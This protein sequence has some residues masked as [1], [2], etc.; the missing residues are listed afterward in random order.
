MDINK[1]I[2]ARIN[3]LLVKKNKKQKELSAFLGI[4]DNVVS[5][6]VHG[7]RV[8]NIEQLIKIADFF[9]TTVDYLVGR[10]NTPSID[11]DTQAICKKVGITEKTLN[12]I[13]DIVNIDRDSVNNDSDTIFN[14]FFSINAAGIDAKQ[15]FKEICETVDTYKFV[16]LYEPIVNGLTEA[17][18]AYR[19]AKII[20]TNKKLLS[21]PCTS[22]LVVTDM[23]E[24][25][26]AQFHRTIMEFEFLCNE[27]VGIEQFSIHKATAKERKTNVNNP[28]E[29][30]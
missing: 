13:K 21:V 1:K 27:L 12:K 16:T 19:T 10:S 7:K 11:I 24:T 26:Y 2:G 25:A 29:G 14:K 4:K 5:Y 17:E 23:I 8:P 22:G 15:L 3:E 9:D 18:Y 20:E 30:E 6:F 28:Q